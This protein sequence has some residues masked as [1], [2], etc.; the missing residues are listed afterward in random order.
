MERSKVKNIF[1]LI[2]GIFVVFLSLNHINTNIYATDD[3][4]P[5][6]DDDSPECL[7]YLKD[8]L[9]DLGQRNTDIQTS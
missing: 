1:L 5:G 8:K 6:M 4:C 7:D 3:A 2:L 9:D